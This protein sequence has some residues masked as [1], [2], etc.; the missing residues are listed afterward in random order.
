MR[1]R[2]FAAVRGGGTVVVRP[3]RIPPPLKRADI[4]R[5][6]VV[7][8]RIR[9]GSASLGRTLHRYQQHALR[10]TAFVHVFDQRGQRL[11][12]RRQPAPVGSP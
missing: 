12:E 4:V 1:R 3:P 9:V 2:Q 7:S 11:I 6:H 5:A 10:D 8:A